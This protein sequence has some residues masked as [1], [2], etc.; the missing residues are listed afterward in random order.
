MK[1]G[2]PI[3]DIM[4]RR[5]R[6]LAQCAAQRDDLAVLA[7]RLEVPLKV[8]DR[9]VAGVHYLRRHPVALGAAV[10]LFAAIERRHL[11]TCVR[12]GFVVWRAYRVFRT[13]NFKSV[14]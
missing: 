8:A 11:W 7:Q 14:V 6:L 5:E 13:T 1:H 12:R 2:N 3:I 4:V 9:V 10:A